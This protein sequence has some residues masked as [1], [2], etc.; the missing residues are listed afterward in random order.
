MPIIFIV[1]C[2]NGLCE[3]FHEDLCG[4]HKDFQ[5][6]KIQISWHTVDTSGT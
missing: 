5:S 6:Q 4:D 3:C 2:D 1:D